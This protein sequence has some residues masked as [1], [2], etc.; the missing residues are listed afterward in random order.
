M[1]ARVTQAATDA[2]RY[3]TLSA[4]GM[5]MLR[6]LREHPA[7]PRFHNRSGNRLLASEVEELRRYECD[8]AT[9]PFVWSPGCPPPWLPSFLAR[10]F[11][12]VP[13]YRARGPPSICRSRWMVLKSS[14]SSL[15]RL[16]PANML[17]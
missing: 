7:A 1:D 12:Q 5:A 11:A 16:E 13:H 14:K 3:P 8:I 4:A 15:S 2:E 10:V 6:R 17:S 9:A